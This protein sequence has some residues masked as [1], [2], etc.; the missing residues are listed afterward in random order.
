MKRSR[1]PVGH[2]IAILTPTLAGGG[3]ERGALYIAAGLLERGHDVDL[4]LYR[5]VC[6][7]PSEVPDKARL[8]VLSNRRD[9]E[10]LTNFGGATVVPQ[11]L[12]SGPTP[13]EIRYPRTALVSRLRRNQLPLLLSMRPPRW[14]ASIA[15][16]VER[17][18]PTALLAINV[19]AA[20]STTMAASL[21]QRPPRIVATLN[22]VLRSRRLLHRARIS[23]PLADA[24]VAVSR[25]IA[26][27]LAGISGMSL[28]RI[29]TIYD[30]VVSSPLD[31]QSLQPVGHSWL[32]QPERPVVLAMGRM[33]KVK[34]FSMLLVAFARLLTTQR[35]ARLIVLGE[36][37]LR[38]NLLALAHKL[39]IAKHVDF[40]GF[41]DNPHTYLAK[42]DLFVLSSRYESF[43]RVLVE[44]MA[45]GCPIVSTDCPYGPNEIL[46]GGRWGELVPVGDA[47]ALA[48]AIARTLDDPPEP[49]ALWARASFFGVERAIDRYEQLLLGEEGVAAPGP[50]G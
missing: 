21:V 32:D 42:A 3:A 46:E 9:A 5:P 47:G 50:P 43:S 33:K 31:R 7:Y 26:T 16:Y 12:I 6:H 18:Q 30:P 14:A 37:P 38:R 19:L 48:D 45:C 13:W 20:A 23:Y 17:E 28:D 40:P 49:D 1:Q 15:T 11:P 8:L 44:A 27:E 36:G 22:D 4:V 41:V 2:R 35:Q 29:H 39:G 25:G 24:A 10:T 34:D